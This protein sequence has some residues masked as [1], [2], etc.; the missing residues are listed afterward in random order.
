MGQWTTETVGIGSLG[1]FARNV[2]AGG[3]CFTHFSDV[4]RVACFCPA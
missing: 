4:Q 1:S 3:F 2:H